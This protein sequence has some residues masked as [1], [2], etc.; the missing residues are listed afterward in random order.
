MARVREFSF[1]ADMR[2]RPELEPEYIISDDRHRWGILWIQPLFNLLGFRALGLTSSMILAFSVISPDF[3]SRDCSAESRSQID[4]QDLL[5]C[6]ACIAGNS[7][8][9]EHKRGV[10]FWRRHSYHMY[11]I[12]LRPDDPRI[13]MNLKAL[14]PW[15]VIQSCSFAINFVTNLWFITY[16]P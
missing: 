7:P 13:Q 2:N 4:R 10:I 3:P 1:S 15:E 6:D 5:Y 14:W 9:P 12:L 11:L 16:R 8:F